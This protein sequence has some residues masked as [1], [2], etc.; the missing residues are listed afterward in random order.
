MPRVFL[1]G[2]HA[3]DK[4]ISSTKAEIIQIPETLT[5]QKHASG[6]TVLENFSLTSSDISQKKVTEKHT[7]LLIFKIER[8]KYFL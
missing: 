6:C 1:K 2:K 3:Q 7:L 5:Q 4:S 8:K